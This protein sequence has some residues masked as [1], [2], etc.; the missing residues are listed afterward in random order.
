MKL[1]FAS[2][3]FEYKHTQRLLLD[4]FKNDSNRK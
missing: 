2:S 3:Y 1:I 4:R